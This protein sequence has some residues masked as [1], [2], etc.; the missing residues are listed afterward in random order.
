[1]SVGQSRICFLVT[2][3]S[4]QFMRQPNVVA[5]VA[6]EGRRHLSTK[7]NYKKPYPYKEKSFGFFRALLDFTSARIN[8]N[9]RI[10]LV[11]GLPCVGK[12]E[13]AK[14][15][16]DNFQLK[17][18]PPVTEEDLF[19]HNGFDIRQLN[20][21]MPTEKMKFYDLDM[22]YAEP[23]PKNMLHF[24]STQILFFKKRFYQYVEALKHVLHT[25]KDGCNLQYTVT[26]VSFYTESNI[27]FLFIIKIVS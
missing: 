18:M 22:F 12:S 1:M 19:I 10:I 25:G 8:E 13:F 15:L 23:D 3:C 11:E 4:Q 21:A 2:R 27:R 24:G 26:E 5:P 6:L 16:A 20:D 14:N 9:S 7:P 17:Y